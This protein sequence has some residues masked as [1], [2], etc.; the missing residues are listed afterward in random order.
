[1]KGLLKVGPIL[2]PI[3]TLIENE[4]RSKLTLSFKF[5]V[6]HFTDNT[7]VFG[8]SKFIIIKMLK[9]YNNQNVKSKH[10]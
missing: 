4:S 2:L 1:M 9:V 6:V 10:A 5:F 3:I 7:R 8:N